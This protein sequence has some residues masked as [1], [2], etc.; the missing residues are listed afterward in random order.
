MNPTF[1]S[2]MD[3]DVL[4]IQV[5][6]RR[7][8]KPELFKALTV[9]RAGRFASVRIC[10]LALIG[11]GMEGRRRSDD[12]LLE[13]R[14]GSDSDNSG[15]EAEVAQSPVSRGRGVPRNSAGDTS[16]ARTDAQTDSL[17]GDLMDSVGQFA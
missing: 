14:G 6:I 16:I 3:D 13:S 1:G 4:R 7:S 9:T 17:V 5:T 10:Q 12:R 15:R 2:E 8:T 11:L